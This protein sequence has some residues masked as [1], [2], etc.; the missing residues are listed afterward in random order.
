MFYVVYLF[1]NA[2]SQVN[3]FLA[4]RSK[5]NATPTPVDSHKQK[6]HNDF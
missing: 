2:Q 3:K 6:S 5:T 4:V 1:P